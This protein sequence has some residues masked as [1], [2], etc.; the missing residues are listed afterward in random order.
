MELTFDSIRD[1]KLYQRKSGYRFSLDA[2][3]LYDFIEQP[4]AKSIADLG[5]G[6]GIIGILL[7]RKFKNARVLLIELQESLYDL[8]LRNIEVNGVAD[9]V[10]IIKEDIKEKNKMAKLSGKFDL[11]VSNPPFRKPVSGKISLEREKALARHEISLKLEDLISTAGH[12]LKNRGRLCIIYLPD[13]LP[14]VFDSLRKEGLEPKRVRFVHGR[15]G[16]PAKMVLVESVKA[17][18]AG[19]SVEPPLIVYKPDGSY[20]EEVRAI[21]Q[22]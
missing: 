4:I 9:R 13:R 18:R 21:Y 14:E 8:A 22:L 20:T 19:L 17:S 12:M 3:L 15:A 16:L 1:I 2:L 6:S 7:A 10:E 5:A 11:V